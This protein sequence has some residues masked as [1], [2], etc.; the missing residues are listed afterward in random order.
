V[1][2]QVT[3][4]G[5]SRVVKDQHV[6]LSVTRDGITYNGIG[7]N[8]AH[9]FPLLN[10]RQPVDVVFTLDENEWNGNKNLQMKV[11]DIRES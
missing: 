9:K 7:F 8:L 11:V 6:K 3:D 2:K 4:S 1:V 10:N 5:F